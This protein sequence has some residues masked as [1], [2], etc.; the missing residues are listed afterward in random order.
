MDG[1]VPFIFV[2]FI[3]IRVE[4]STIVHFLSCM[5]KI[6]EKIIYMSLYEYCASHELLIIMNSELKINDSTVNQ[7]HTITH[8]NINVVILVNVTMFCI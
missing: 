5:S 8:N 7:L 3:E 4:S 2:R 6:L 1:S